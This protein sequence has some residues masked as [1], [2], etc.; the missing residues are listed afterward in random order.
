[1]KKLYLILPI[2]ILLPIAGYGQNSSEIRAKNTVYFEL[3][4]SGIVYSLN[5]ER[6]FK[7]KITLRVGAGYLPPNSN[8]IIDE[9]VS[10]P[11]S[12]SY[13]KSMGENSFIELGIGGTYYKI[14]QSSGFFLSPIVGIREQN[15]FNGGAVARLNFI[16]VFQMVPKR[17]IYLTAGLSI[18]YNF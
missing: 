6:I 9:M 12:S 4:G 18:G 13:L 16:P 14:D 8:S 1:M 2:I 17:N 3:F 7:N 15:L 10:L 5:Y 11:I